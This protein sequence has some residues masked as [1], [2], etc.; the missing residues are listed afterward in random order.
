MIIFLLQKLYGSIHAAFFIKFYSEDTVLGF[1]VMGNFHIF[2][3]D[4]V[5]GKH[6]DNVCQGTGLVCNIHM[7]TVG[8]FDGAAGSVDKGIKM[9][10]RNM[11]MFITPKKN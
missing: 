10:G 11:A 4:I 3:T 2:N 6:G 7:D 9:E 8:S 5:S 1:S